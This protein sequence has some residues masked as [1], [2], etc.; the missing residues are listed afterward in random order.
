[1][2]GSLARRQKG[3][4]DTLGHLLTPTSGGGAVEVGEA[5]EGRDVLLLNPATIWSVHICLSPH[6]SPPRPRVHVHVLPHTAD[7]PPRD[8]SPALSSPR[9]GALVSERP[10]L[11]QILPLS[12]PS[13]VTPHKP[14]DLPKPQCPQLYN[15]EKMPTPFSLP[16]PDLKSESVA[17]LAT[18][19]PCLLRRRVSSG[20]PGGTVPGLLAQFHACP[21]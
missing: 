2:M 19:V 4:R 7:A 18:W 21:L 12:L 14:L 8:G 1:M 16:F 17:L 15:Q 3:G 20:E 10:A 5:K 6:H 11:G 13:W 9:R